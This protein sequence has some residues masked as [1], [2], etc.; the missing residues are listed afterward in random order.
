ML[1]LSGCTQMH[2]LWVAW[3]LST[4]RLFYVQLSFYSFEIVCHMEGLL[5]SHVR[6]FHNCWGK[7]EESTTLVYVHGWR[8]SGLIDAPRTCQKGWILHIFH[9]PIPSCQPNEAWKPD[10]P[11]LETR[12]QWHWRVMHEQAVRISD[13]FLWPNHQVTLNT[14]QCFIT[15]NY[16]VNMMHH[17]CIRPLMHQ[18][19]DLRD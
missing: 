18:T 2:Y 1:W 7:V 15:K 3:F 8:W 14:T 11:S 9:G 4:E 13:S 19:L 12:W 5:L 6:S 10:N 17:V 16:I